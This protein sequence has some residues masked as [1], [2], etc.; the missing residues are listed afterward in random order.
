MIAVS[1]TIAATERA[2]DGI[3][4]IQTQAAADRE[5]CGAALV[6]RDGKLFGSL[7]SPR[8][9]TSGG[10]WVHDLILPIA[11]FEGGLLSVDGAPSAIF[12]LVP[13]YG[14]PRCDTVF[15]PGLD[16]CLECG[17]LLPHP[18]SEPVDARGHAV[19]ARARLDNAPERQAHHA[20]RVALG[21]VGIPPN[22]ARVG[23]VL[24]RF[25]PG[26]TGAAHAG[27]RDIPID[28][29][30]DDNGESLVLSAEVARIPNGSFEPFYRHV[31]TLN[32]DGLGPCRLGIREMS[33]IITMF[34]PV[35]SITRET[36]PGRVQAFVN[37][38]ERCQGGLK[39]FFGAEPTG[40][41]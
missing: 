26:P 29:T 7:V 13:E 34:E 11:A 41:E 15:E 14:C 10:T 36:F 37:E 1:T 23:P 20:V 40:V 16:R 12:E 8:K 33:V 17:I 32:G 27:E 25:S 22:R 19:H 30:V 38:I 2:I 9:R 28:L 39:R 5:I 18:W 21:S 31:L 3:G 6:D 24:W 35:S 4:Y